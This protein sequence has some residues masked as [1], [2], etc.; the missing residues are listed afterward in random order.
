MTPKGTSSRR[1]GCSSPIYNEDKINEWCR[2]IP[3]L[4]VRITLSCGQAQRSISHNGEETAFLQTIPS[5]VRFCLASRI[6]HRLTASIIDKKKIKIC[7]YIPASV[8][9]L[10][11][12]QCRRT[13]LI[14]RKLF[15]FRSFD[16]F[17]NSTKISVVHEI[18]S[19]RLKQKIQS[20]SNGNKN[21]DCP[22]RHYCFRLKYNLS[23]AEVGEEKAH[24]FNKS[25]LCESECMIISLNLNMVLYLLFEKLFKY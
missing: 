8:Y 11:F 19:R 2:Q 12:V 6:L 3:F 15:L 23:I 4:N 9:T 7:I 5:I 21:S 17:I 16:E 1:I 18:K 22:S 24:A 20:Y 10:G 25:I 13:R 14:F